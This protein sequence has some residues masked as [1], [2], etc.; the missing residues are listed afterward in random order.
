MVVTLLS[1]SIYHTVKYFAEPGLAHEIE[2]SSKQK[3]FGRKELKTRK[4][5]SLQCT[6]YLTSS[7]LSFQLTCQRVEAKFKSQVFLL[8]LLFNLRF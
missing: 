7:Y 8:I 5:K 2:I 4:P 3:A 1:L 6:S